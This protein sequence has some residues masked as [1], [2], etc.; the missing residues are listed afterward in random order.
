[1]MQIS[2]FYIKTRKK[3]IW[4]N[5]E[6]VDFIFVENLSKNTWA[7][8]LLAMWFC[9]GVQTVYIEGTIAWET[10]RPGSSVG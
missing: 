6:I 8:T 7:P 4:R 1:M 2:V 10:N 3:F 9:S 5:S